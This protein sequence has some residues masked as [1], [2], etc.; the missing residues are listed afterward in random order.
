MSQEMSSALRW[1]IIYKAEKEASKVR[2]NLKQQ[3]S[4]EVN[5]GQIYIVRYINSYYE[6]VKL[7]TQLLS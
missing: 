6:G 3:V 7:T 5:E 4:W 1:C 2:I